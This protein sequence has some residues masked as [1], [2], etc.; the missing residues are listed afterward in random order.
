M[1]KSNNGITVVVNDRDPAE[2]EARRAAAAKRWAATEKRYKDQEE[3]AKEQLITKVLSLQKSIKNKNAD[4][5]KEE[6]MRREF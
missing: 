1:I 5:E 3:K 2:A 6:N 4:I